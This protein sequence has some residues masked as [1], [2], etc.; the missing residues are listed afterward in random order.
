MTLEGISVLGR[1][2]PISWSPYIP[3]N[4][5]GGVLLRFRPHPD[6]SAFSS[7]AYLAR[8]AGIGARFAVRKQEIA[9]SLKSC[10]QVH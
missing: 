6:T 3:W 2:N 8:Q 9:T 4:T 10:S 7:L 1:L 5:E